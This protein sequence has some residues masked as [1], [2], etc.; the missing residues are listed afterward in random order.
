[1]AAL[2]GATEIKPSFWDDLEASLI[3]A[4]LGPGMTA[5]V[6]EELR[7]EVGRQGWTR[8]GDVREGLRGLLLRRLKPAP[9]EALGPKPNV[10]VFVGVNGSGKTTAIARLAWRW[11]GLGA[12]VL[13]AAADTYR[14]AAVDQLNEWARRLHVEIS[15][16]QPGSDPG[17]VVH[18]ACQ[19]ALAHR[20]DL[21][22]VD[23]SGRM[24]TSHNLMAELQKV[25]RVAG[26]VV[27][28]APHEVLL[29]LD[30]TTGQNGLAQARAFA[31]A[32]PLSGV[33][34]A[35]LDTSA[36]GGVGL[37]ISEAMGLPIWY[38]G[39]GEQEGDLLPFEPAAFVDGL[40]P[41]A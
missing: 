32:V 21:V 37:A 35:K 30:A 18:D 10:F 33:I 19:A 4:D 40:L 38:V 26:R 36:R 41:A 28:G 1:V 34:L 8:A 12:K 11:R 27:P 25:C 13:L 14:A 20:V 9:S 7:L 31:Q 5:G 15:A 17:A 39:V 6:L 16:G 23:T 3:A 2:V 22:L 24:H 29:V